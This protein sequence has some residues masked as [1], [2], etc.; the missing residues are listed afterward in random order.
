MLDEQFLYMAVATS[1]VTGLPLAFFPRVIS[2]S[3]AQLG[4]A[5]SLM[6]LAC[7]AAGAFPASYGMFF[8]VLLVTVSF[9]LLI[10]FYGGLQYAARRKA[11][12]DLA[13]GTAM[14]APFMF[15]WVYCIT[16]HS[17]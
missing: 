17:R 15:L 16:H 3:A 12:S 11:W 10:L 2:L 4:V 9:V 7:S 5:T 6:L 1:F 8:D 13:A 14:L